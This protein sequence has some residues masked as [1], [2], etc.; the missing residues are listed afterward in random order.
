MI[1]YLGKD[2]ACPMELSLSLIGGK[3]KAVILWHLAHDGTLRFGMLRRKFP[4]V[5]QKMLTQQLRELE[6]DGMVNRVVYPE[7][8]PKVEYSLT[9]IGL[10]LVPVLDA[11]SS[12]GQQFS[13][14]ACP[15]LLGEAARHAAS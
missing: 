5:T 3:W 9:E 12:W 1:S 11:L 6:R 15:S 8:P 2:F 10:S 7:V 14:T 4:S 13:G